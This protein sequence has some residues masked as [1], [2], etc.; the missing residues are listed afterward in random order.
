MLPSHGANP[1]YLYKSLN[2]RMP[3][4][5]IDFSV[6]INPFGPPE[7]IRKNWDRFFPFVADYPDPDM[8]EL[9]AVIAGKENVSPENI[10]I[11]NGAAELIFI[12][13]AAL[14][15][16]EDVLIVEPAFSEYRKACEPFSKRIS[17]YVLKE[18]DNW[19]LNVEE[20]KT[21]LSGK[22]AVF[23]CHPNN[24]TG[25]VFNR[26]ALL[27]IIQDAKKKHVFVV[28]D[29]AFYDFALENVSILNC[30]SS[31][32]NVIILRSLTKMYAI[33]GLRLGFL[34]A[35][36]TVIRRLKKFQV[37]WSVNAIGQRAGIEALKDE[38][39]VKKTKRMISQE[40][41][42]MFE[43]LHE[44]GFVVADSSVNFYLL[45]EQPKKDM[46]PLIR[47]LLER[48]IVPRHT[49]NFNGLSGKYIRL[50]VKRKE[51]NDRLLS[52]LKEWKD[53]C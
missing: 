45:R 12:I 35:D 14:L 43:H 23:L 51:E 6:N 48:G 29:E 25:K 19:E 33:A 32:S 42:R 11:G 30:L 4:N 46:L 24:P 10:L 22:K 21:A 1:S 50:A 16:N 47:F 53:K 40:R 36:E 39:Y 3:E 52:A 27:E 13:A 44:L 15:Q 9:R 20:L 8:A 37:H 7:C 17:S 38:D 28:L 31:F 26:E 49:Y 41:K 34:L 2:I 18:E 5:I